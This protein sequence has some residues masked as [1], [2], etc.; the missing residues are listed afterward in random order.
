[1]ELLHHSRIDSG[2][3]RD[4]TT[5]PI[6]QLTVSSPSKPSDRAEIVAKAIL[7]H[8]EGK[9]LREI[10]K[11]LNVTYEGLRIWMLKDQP[12]A[13]KQAQELGLI[14]RIVYA[15]KSMD[16]AKNSLDIARARE[17]A[18]FARWDAERRLPGLFA[19][20]QETNV[21][22]VAPTLNIM[23]VKDNVEVLAHKDV[24]S[25]AVEDK[26]GKT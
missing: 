12:K 6:E 23:I 24:M 14:A 3:P 15:D 10:A 22:M 16:E 4:L 21:Q 26:T 17:E 11:D 19:L 18:K 25:N 1:M 13:Y 2:Q 20:K 5:N 7:D 9:S 8:A